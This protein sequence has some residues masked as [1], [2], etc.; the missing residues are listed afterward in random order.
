M[1]SGLLLT[2]LGLAGML[3]VRNIA[4]TNLEYVQT[5]RDTEI[6]KKVAWSL[7]QMP[8]SLLACR[9]A[10]GL[11]GPG[12]PLQELMGHFFQALNGEF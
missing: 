12:R 7:T 9:N 2:Q 1:L 5:K 8:G 6:Q 11:T 3:V 4:V 10:G